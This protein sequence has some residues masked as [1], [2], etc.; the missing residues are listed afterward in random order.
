MHRPVALQPSPIQPLVSTVMKAFLF[1][2]LATAFFA[3][4]SAQAA[5]AADYPPQHRLSP[6]EQA[7]WDAEQRRDDRFDRDHRLT[8]NERRRWEEGHNYGYAQ[9]HRV[10]REERA[11]WEDSYRR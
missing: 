5:P 11:R 1:A 3:T 6:R 8:R 2:A 4:T 10:S 7:R 9:N